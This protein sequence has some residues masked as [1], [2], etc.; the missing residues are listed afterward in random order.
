MGCLSLLLWRQFGWSASL[1]FQGAAVLFLFII[2][3]IDL[4]H[5]IIP[6]SLSLTLLALG[7]VAVYVQQPSAQSLERSLLGATLGGGI[8]YGV[9]WLGEKIFKQEAMGGGDIKLLSAC[10]AWLGYEGALATLFLS[11][12]TGGIFAAAILFKLK[13]RRQYIPFGPFLAFGWIL[14]ILFPEAGDYISR[15]YALR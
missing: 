4:E 11:C 8:L 14:L 10:G 1:L 13:K 5:K 6:D 15:W 3:G 12:L 2:A 9:A 7:F